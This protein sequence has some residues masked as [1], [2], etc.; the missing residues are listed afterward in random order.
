MWRAHG[1]Y[2]ATLR[3]LYLEQDVTLLQC[4]KRLACS[5]A[6][7]FVLFSEA[8]GADGIIAALS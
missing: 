6:P 1:R 5:G 3:R 2:A 4:F 8:I 7:E